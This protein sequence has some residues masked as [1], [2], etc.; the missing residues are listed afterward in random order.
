MA[1]QK[2]KQGVCRWFDAVKG[3]GFIA[4]IGGQA[5]IFVH[6]SNIAGCEGDY[7]SLDAGEKV[8]YNEEMTDRPGNKMQAVNVTSLDR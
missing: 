5:D 3:Y 1:Q 6:F 8:E 2:K 7:R 4:P